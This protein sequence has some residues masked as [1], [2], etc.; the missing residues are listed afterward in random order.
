M[1]A[2]VHFMAAQVATAAR[3]CDNHGLNEACGLTLTAGDA[4]VLSPGSAPSL[5]WLNDEA[6]PAKARRKMLRWAVL[7]LAPGGVVI[8][9]GPARCSPPRGLRLVDKL[10]V[11]VSWSTREEIRVL[12][13]I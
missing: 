12:A 6:W 7:L 8:S 9:Y 2:T 4:L 3:V 5:L 1:L 13:R 11:P 10:F